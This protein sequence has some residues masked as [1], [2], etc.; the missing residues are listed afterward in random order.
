[1]P[2]VDVTERI[3]RPPEEVHAFLSDF[4]RYPEWIPFTKEVTSVDRVDGVVGTTYTE[5][6]TGG[7]SRWEVVAYE[8]GRREV[9]EGD[10]G[11]ATVRIEMTM[12]PEGDGTRYR[13]VIDYRMKVPVIGAVLDKLVLG[14]QMR[15]GTRETVA[16]LKRLLESR[17]AAR[18]AAPEAR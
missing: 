8:E 4:D 11:I 16:N 18:P 17:D 9:H 6:G 10:I 12:A 3:A 2:R 14:P 5:R 7:R 1:M 15:K 13:H